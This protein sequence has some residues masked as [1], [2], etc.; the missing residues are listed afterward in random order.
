MV[1]DLS[2]VAPQ[3]GARW[4]RILLSPSQRQRVPSFLSRLQ[5]PVKECAKCSLLSGTSC[6][7]DAK[8]CST[9][10]HRLD[11]RQPWNSG[12]RTCIRTTMKPQ[13][14]SPVAVSGNYNACLVFNKDDVYY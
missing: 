5:K 8:G 7:A 2:V 14:K 11:A 3:T 12:G 6:C 9:T 10:R 1:V 13:K 4:T